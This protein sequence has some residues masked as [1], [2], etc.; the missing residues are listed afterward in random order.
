[1]LHNIL[2]LIFELHVKKKYVYIWNI[3]FK[4]SFLF[5]NITG[6]ADNWKYPFRSYDLTNPTS[7]IY[8][9]DLV[10]FDNSFGGDT[11]FF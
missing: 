4:K 11:D 1:M 3:F 9:R 7:L 5:I 8:N 2:E 6:I 10:I